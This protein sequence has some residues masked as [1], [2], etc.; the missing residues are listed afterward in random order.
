MPVRTDVDTSALD[1]CAQKGLK[2]LA[3]PAKQVPVVD[4]LLPADV[5]GALDDVITN[6]WNDKTATPDD[7]IA[8]FA[9]AMKSAGM[10]GGSSRWHDRSRRGRRSSP[11]ARLPAASPA[12]GSMPVLA[13]LAPGPVMGRSPAPDLDGRA[14]AR[15]G[16]RHRRRRLCRRR[17]SG[18]CRSPSPRPSC[19]RST[20]MS[21]SSNIAGCSS[22]RAGSSRCRISSIFGVLFVGCCLVDRL[23]PRRLPRPEG[24]LRE[25]ASAPSS[26]I[27][28]R[29]R[30][31][32]PGLIWQ[33]LMN[34]GLGIQKTVRD[35]GWESF[36]FDWA[37][38]NA[39]AIYAL[40]IAAIWQASGPRHGADAG[41]A[42]RRRRRTV[43]G[44]AGRRH[45]GLA[46]LCLHRPALASADDRH[47][48]RAA[49]DLGHQELRP[50]RRPHQWRPGHRVRDAGQIRHGQSVRAPEH[51]PCRRRIDRDADH[52]GLVARALALRAVFPR[53][54][55]RPA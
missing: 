48:R 46:R 41:R 43:E 55:G 6:F 27:P 33:W 10:S 12:P 14:R 16:L 25:H 32:S 29:C 54:R 30:S 13:L 28:M 44:G 1:S 35:L 47:R 2:L 34:P 45:P 18:R 8:K 19:C 51:R 24:A 22:R 40:V 38:N 42:A 50:R 52:R 3:D 5:V 53:R 11:S 21:A 26:S 49:L 4:M 9:A 31:S 7:M 20:S 39:M 36:T 17:W 37:V 15:A 23:P